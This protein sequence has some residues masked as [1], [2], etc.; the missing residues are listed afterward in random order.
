MTSSM[1]EKNM[2]PEVKTTSHKPDL[3]KE[4]LYV[5][6][7]VGGTKIQSCLIGASGRV[8]ARWKGITPR[9]CPPEETVNEIERS[10]RALLEAEGMVME[11]LA[12]VGVAIPGVVETETGHV[13]VTPN[14]NLS[15]MDLGNILGQRLGIPVI[16]GNDGNLGTLGEAWLGSARH[17]KSVIG[18]FVGTGVGSGAVINGKLWIGAGHAAGEI[19]H[20]VVQVPA[21]SW[22]SRLPVFAQDN[23]PLH[24]KKSGP[25]V[26]K[27]MRHLPGVKPVKTKVTPPTGDTVEITP[28]SLAPYTPGPFGPEPPVMCGC[29]NYGCLES[30]A[31]RTAIE[32]E[33]RSA[34]AN[35]AKSVVTELTG[36]DLSLIRS[37]TL[38]KALKRGDAVVSAIIHYNA[39]VLAYACLTVRHMLDPEVIVLGGGV[40]EACHQFIMPIIEKVLENDKLPASPSNRR[41]VLSSLGDDAVALG[42]V[43]LARMAHHD[44]PLTHETQIMPVY[45]ILRLDLEGDVCVNDDVFHNDFYILANGKVC[46]RGKL[47]KKEPHGFRRKDIELA[48]EGPVQLLVL[49]TK[50]ASEVSLS[51]KSIEYL[52]RRGIE[53]RILP[54]EEAIECFNSAEVHRAA[55]FHL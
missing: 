7:D 41:V 2:N 43:A 10:V 54:V 4:P 13:V 12:A 50:H 6:I 42:A 11:D 31:S 24:G 9:D 34:L 49:A 48:C 14:M 38:S 15:G 16:L 51:K 47:P 30:L 20:M 21:E 53:F 3:A 27:A 55:V 28:P 23:L 19:G 1:E 33:I 46:S 17:A 35:G 52:I 39:E 26:P 45:P 29:G 32:R 22:K 25:E 8:F 40:M 36:G 5:G 18:I 44:L 37:G